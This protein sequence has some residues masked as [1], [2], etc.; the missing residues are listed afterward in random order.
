MS[1]EFPSWRATS[2]A[3]CAEVCAKLQAGAG[4]VDGHDFRLTAGKQSDA[5]GCGLSGKGS[6]QSGFAFEDRFGGN[7]TGFRKLNR[8]YRVTRRKTRM[9]IHFGAARARPFVQARGCIG[10]DG[11][12]AGRGI[13]GETEGMAARERGP[14]R[15]Y[16]SGWTVEPRQI[17]GKKR[18]A[19]LCAGLITDDRGGQK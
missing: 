19:N 2:N 10:G 15:G 18:G 5:G 4:V 1:S 17:C 9:E 3:A 11:N 6:E 12:R 16:Q 13:F 14:E 8:R 7:G